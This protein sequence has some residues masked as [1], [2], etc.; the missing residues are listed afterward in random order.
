MGKVP[1]ADCENCPLINR[2]LAKTRG[3]QGSDVLFVARS[4]GYYEA[5]NGNSFTGPAADI[6]WYLLKQ[7]G[8]D[9]DSIR[10]T[11]AVLCAPEE[12]K[13]PPAALKACSGRLKAE[14]ATAKLVIA[15]GSEA[16]RVLTGMSIERARGYTHNMGDYK[17]VATNHPAAVMRDDSIFPNLQKDFKRAFHPQPPPTFPEVKVI[18]DAKSAIECLNYLSTYPI[19]AADIESRG[20]LTHRAT[21]ISIQFSVNGRIAYVLGER[22][23]L[24]T[25][26]IFID[27]HLRPFFEGDTHFCW[28]NGVFD[29][30]VLRHTYGIKARI[31]HDTILQSYTLDERS[32]QH[33][34]EYCLMEEFS[35][36]KY[37]DAEIN[38]IKKTGIVT[39]YDKFYKYAG[40]DVGGTKQL[41]DYYSGQSK[42]EDLWEKPYLWPIIP[43]QEFLRDVELTGFKYNIEAA[44][45]MFENELQPELSGLLERIRNALDK[46]LFNPNST[47]HCAALYYD[48]W[49]IK[50]ALQARPDKARSV[51]DAARQ[52]VIE[53]RF[54]CFAEAMPGATPK[55]VDKKREYII[56]V[57]Q[58]IDRYKKL[59]KQSSQYI[60]G[61][62]KEAI[63]DPEGRIHTHL[64]LGRTV[65]GRLSSTE[66][67][68]QNISRTKPGMPDIRKLFE[69]PQGRKIVQADY[70]QAELRVIA[71]LS[72]D[73]DLTSIYSEALDLHNIAAERFYGVDFQPE[74]RSKAKNMNFGVAFRQSAHTFQEKHG[75]PSDEA[76]RFIDWWWRN[77]QGV[78]KWEK[79]IEK[80][81][82]DVGYISSPF[83]RRRRFH[84]LT[85]ENIQAV[86]RE[87]IN[88]L[89]QTTASDLTLTSALLLSRRIDPTRSAILLLVHDSIIAEVDDDYIEVYSQLCREVMESRAKEELGWELPFL[90]DIG[91]GQTWAE[92]K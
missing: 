48:E 65:T 33:A 81:V 35:W 50:H 64:N 6:L 91:V 61:M 18:E 14:A 29:T 83:G 49:K 73:P 87:A 43:A 10:L 88:F 78:Y 7:N 40:W 2:P 51:D 86:Y 74:Q 85:K 13:V 56:I 59:Q 15:G 31:D 34:L 17:L 58:G 20:G 46:P 8:V 30:K 5:E 36:P 60:V 42:K 92:A 54:T 68:L 19:I 38:K 27:D 25:D 11:N 57:T 75:I 37:E 70:S 44:A 24:F 69:A 79:G 47:V 52:E 67:N 84:L 80:Q 16:V 72:G 3:P 71:C 23:G 82:H 89:P 32:G 90:C 77:F 55:A 21:L 39:D 12:G 41:F 28:H 53:G 4:P 62:V 76:Q 66:P 45:D 26:S 1:G 63:D 22:S 9:R